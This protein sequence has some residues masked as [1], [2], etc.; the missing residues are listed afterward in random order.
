M[1]FVWLAGRKLL[2]KRRE[3]SWEGD[4]IEERKR[5]EKGNDGEE[6]FCKQYAKR[7]QKGCKKCK[8]IFYGLARLSL[9]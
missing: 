2:L 7:V 8:S 4:L 5:E 1:R 6:L 9:L 3:N